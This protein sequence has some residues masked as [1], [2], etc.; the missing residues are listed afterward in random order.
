MPANDL[1]REQT[2]QWPGIPIPPKV[3][4]LVESF[5]SFLDTETEEAWKAWTEL[6]VLEGVIE[7]GSKMVQGH[8]GEWT[9]RGQVLISV[10]WGGKQ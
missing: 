10:C 3:K 1:G 7:I 8:A 9:I 2:P 4:Q 5:Y 6:F